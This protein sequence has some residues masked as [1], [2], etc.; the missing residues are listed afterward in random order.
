MNLF[1]IVVSVVLCLMFLVLG[2]HT[3]KYI[4][5]F[6]CKIKVIVNRAADKNIKLKDFN[7]KPRDPVSNN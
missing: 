7:Y 5:E 2:G 1:G 4:K 3:L 6:A